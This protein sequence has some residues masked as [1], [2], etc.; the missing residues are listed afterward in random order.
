LGHRTDHAESSSVS[1]IRISIAKQTEKFYKYENSRG[2]E[3]LG[4]KEG[5]E[6]KLWFAPKPPKRF[7][8]L[9]QEVQMDHWARDPTT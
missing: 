5:K 4:W 7:G 3:E 6:Y 8:G 9:R 2:R 1:H